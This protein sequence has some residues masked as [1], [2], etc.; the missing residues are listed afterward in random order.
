MV[1]D[2]W[3]AGRLSSDQ[4]QFSWKE[5]TKSRPPAGTCTVRPGMRARHA[6][7]RTWPVRTL[8]I[9]IDAYGHNT[10]EHGVQQGEQRAHQVLLLSSDGTR[11]PQR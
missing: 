10:T 3:A 5:P 8:I 11:R 2:L 9:V 4:V 6:A 1:T 7:A